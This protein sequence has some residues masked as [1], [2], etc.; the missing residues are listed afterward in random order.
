MKS[1]VHYNSSSLQLT[2]SVPREDADVA[3]AECQV[4]RP[5]NAASYQ[6]ESQAIKNH[7]ARYYP[8]ECTN[9]P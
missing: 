6:A 9:A 2:F 5:E 8:G 3:F 7:G 4:F 1:V